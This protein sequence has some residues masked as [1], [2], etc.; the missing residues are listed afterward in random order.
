M[1]AGFL[2]VLQ[3]SGDGHVLAVG[4]RIDVDLDRVLEV[5]VE[6]DG[7]V[8]EGLDGIAQVAVAVEPFAVVD[9]LHGAPAQHVGGADHHG[10]ADTLGDGPRFRA[11]RAGLV[12]RLP[13]A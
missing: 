9:D 12:G 11:R 13:E 1:D 7:A 6:Q 5:A 8:A 4:E 3:D 10:V 2:D